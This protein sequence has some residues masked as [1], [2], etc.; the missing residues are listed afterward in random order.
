MTDPTDQARERLATSFG[1]QEVEP[2]HKSR[3]VGAM[4]ARVAARYDLM[5]DLMSAGVHRLWK[6]AMI[7]W[8][9]PQPEMRLLDVAGGTG[10]I[11]FR[12]LDRLARRGQAPPRIVV[13]DVNPQ[14]LEV[15]RDRA[16]DDNRPDAI[17]WVCADAEAL[18]L[19]D[20][21]IDA[22]T[23]AFGIRNVTR[24]ER[25][26]AEARRVLVPGGRFLCLEFA[27]VT[28]PALRRAYDAYSFAVLP[29][30]GERVA[31]DRDAY[32]YLAESIR[33]FP[34]QAT[35][36]RMIER[37]G[38][39]RVRHRDLSGGIAALHSAWRL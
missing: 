18:P 4:F 32:R 38:L 19:P 36:G 39:D 29:W 31:G 11:A 2:Q 6:A 20:R 21:S 12:V 27:T 10:D 28:S 37:A 22:Y 16:I 26:L 17:A 34:D 35:F 23:I 8:L 1:Y 9:A 25:V 14:M 15:G 33:R 3:L 7:D 30:L 13:S 5:N 24:I